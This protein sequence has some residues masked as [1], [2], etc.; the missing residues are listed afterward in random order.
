MTSN[1]T[2]TNNGKRL[3][4][5][6]AVLALIACAFVAFAPTEDSNG[7]STGT[8]VAGTELEGSNVTITTGTDFYINSEVTIT[9]MTGKTVNIYLGENGSVTLPGT[10]ATTTT[11]QTGT[12]NEETKMITPYLG[13]SITGVATKEYSTVD[14]ATGYG[15]VAPASSTVTAG[16]KIISST[17]SNIECYPN[18]AVVNDTLN[19]EGANVMVINGT[20]NA[21]ISGYKVDG[22]DATASVSIVSSAATTGVV[23]SYV[24]DDYPTITSDA[25]AGSV[26]VNSGTI[27]VATTTTGLDKILNAYGSGSANTAGTLLGPTVSSVGTVSTLYVYGEVADGETTAD[28]VSF[29]NATVDRLTFGTTDKFTVGTTEFSSATA[30]TLT[31]SSRT[32]EIPST[33]TGSLSLA[34]GDFTAPSGGVIINENSTLSVGVNAVLTL[35]GTDADAVTLKSAT[36]ETN[37]PAAFNVYGKLTV[38]DSVDEATIL[39]TD[40]TATDD[41]LKGT[42]NAYSTATISEYIIIDATNYRIDGAMKEAI[43]NKDVNS[44]NTY[45][46]FQTVR[47]TEDITISEDIKLGILGQLIID[48]GASITIEDG[49]VLYIG[50]MHNDQSTT[51]STA[52]VV[53]NGDMEIKTGGTFQVVAGKSVDI[54]GDVEVAG[55]F[56]VDTGKTTLKTG[57]TMTVDEPKTGDTDN[58]KLSVT[59][60]F[61]IESGANVRIEGTFKATDISNFGTITIDGT[62]DNSTAG[63]KIS[64]LG[65]GAEVVIN[66]AKFNTDYAADKILTITDE[67]LVLVKNPELKVADD[68][69]NTI[70]I[71]PEKANDIIENVTI[72]ESVTSTTDSKGNKTYYNTMDI[73]GLVSYDSEATPASGSTGVEIKLTGGSEDESGV[74]IAQTFSYGEKVKFVNAGKLTVSGQLN[75]TDSDSTQIDNEN[76]TITVTGAIKALKKIDGT[77]N[78]AMY[79]TNE[80]S[81]RYYNYTTLEDAVAAAPEEIEI[82]GTI[83]ITEDVTI[84]SPIE[85][86]ATG[87]TLINVGTDKNRDVTLTV[88]NGAELKGATDIQVYGTVYFENNKDSNKSNN[89]VSDVYTTDGTDARYTNIYTALAGATD[90]DTVEIT[91]EDGAVQITQN[92]TII[93]GVTLKVPAGK[94][95]QLADGVTVTVE[96]TL[97]AW[98]AVTAQTAFAEQA[99]VEEKTSAIDVT[100]TF[101]SVAAVE[102]ANYFIPGA[103]YTISNDD[104]DFN[105]VTPVEAAAAV[106]G[107]VT[108]PIEIYG[109][110]AV[111]EV[112]FVGTD[113]ERVNI[114]VYGELVADSISLTYANFGVNV[115]GSYTGAVGAASG[116]VEVVDATGFA[117]S[118]ATIN[119][120]SKVVITG[121]PSAFE[122][123]EDFDVTI[124]AGT[125]YAESDTTGSTAYNFTVD[126]LTVAS[127]AT[128]NVD[129]A[130]NV[131]SI[132]E[133]LIVEGTANATDG[134]RIVTKDLIVLGTFTVGSAVSADGILAGQAQATNAFV[135]ISEKDTLGTAATLNADSISG[136][137]VVYLSAGSTVTDKLIEGM[138]STEYYVEDALYLTVY[139]VSGYE[140]L[141]NTIS[142]PDLAGKEVSA[143]QYVDSDGKTVKIDAS[144]KE[145]VGAVKTITAL[146]DYDVYEIT[147]VAEYGI[148]DIYI[149]GEL[150]DTEGLSGAGQGEIKTMIAVG[151][152]QITYRLNNYFAGDV[153]ITLNGEALT[154]GKFTITSDM[155][156]EDDDG[157]PTEYKIVLTGVEAAAPE[158]P[159]SGD[160]GSSDGLG[161]TDYLLIVLVVLIVV[162]AIIVAIRLM[163]S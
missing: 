124:A 70:T 29:T 117:V 55:V 137:K 111:G 77:V 63:V 61:V 53:M 28:A 80:N 153:K 122:Q 155:P 68:R 88:N 150:I 44:S 17:G 31:V 92:I 62:I 149:D 67:N 140:P 142:F 13:L 130:G 51:S 60:D 42:F 138:K 85:V 98:D 151:E 163:R 4:A 71:A 81:V 79:E 127:G 152:H 27:K 16:I 114:V 110:N 12:F 126:T 82:L 125:V 25:T 112:T 11:I 23:L 83:T 108:G 39:V 52:S 90:G 148:T 22:T 139:A 156:F 91:K 24:A 3:M 135:G 48:E 162:M 65:N 46:Q 26:T 109:E 89:I 105:Y 145:K 131:A 2:R 128:F 95:I 132:T 58:G 161:L 133:D 86:D 123:S 120:T 93:D 34:S 158:N 49:A 21:S 5:A 143:W 38:P 47:V 157:T 102:Y 73:S 35:E 59:E 76:G 57:A 45:S 116:T 36:V 107:D 103:Y 1:V 106:A 99:S 41:S 84:P 64:M 134:G 115:I 56:Q 54:Y 14:A 33:I 119:E 9:S 75:Q 7:L 10:I 100:G 141:V 113:D 129:G 6:I 147:I 8:P 78:A 104:G 146:M 19:K 136:L 30:T 50:A 40:E 97:D 74:T 87:A 69:I 20:V 94:Q 43:I 96:G 18:G 118:E 159:S 66:S 32:V 154:D 101:V 160:S 37:T 15:V 121:S 144:S 72:A